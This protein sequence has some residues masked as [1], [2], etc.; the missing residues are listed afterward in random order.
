MKAGG[1]G[2]SN[3][4]TGLRCEEEVDFG[5]L[6]ESIPRCSINEILG[7]SDKRKVEFRYGIDLDNKLVAKSF[8]DHSFYTCLFEDHKIT[9]KK[10]VS[11][12]LLPDDALLFIIKIKF[13]K[14]SGSI[15]KK[16]TTCDYKQK[17]YL[18]LVSQIH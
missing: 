5:K 11:S 14:V 4:L 12:K 6:L 1:T 10:L 18:K 9:G 2:V 17:Q 7:E 16:R 8:K 13:Q 15:D 3:I